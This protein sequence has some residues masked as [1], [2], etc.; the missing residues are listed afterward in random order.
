T[1]DYEELKIF[2]YDPWA[3]DG[4]VEDL[5]SRFHVDV[6]AA[7]QR[8]AADVGSSCDWM[9]SACTE[10]SNHPFTIRRQLG[11]EVIILRKFLANP[12]PASDPKDADIF[13]V[14]AL[15]GS[16]CMGGLYDT[17][18]TTPLEEFGDDLFE[19]LPFYNAETRHRHLF[20]GS[21]D[22]R[23]LPLDI[24]AQSLLLS[25]GASWGDRPGHL[26]VPPSVT[27][28]ELQVASGPSTGEREILFFMTMVPNNPIRHEIYRQLEGLR[29]S[30]VVLQELDRSLDVW[31]KIKERRFDVVTMDHHAE[32][33]TSTCVV[34]GAADHIDCFSRLVVSGEESRMRSSIFC[35]CPPAENTAA[36]TKR[37]FDAI[38]SGCIPVVISFPTLW[39]S[40]ISWWRTD[41]APIEW[42]LPFPSD[43]Q[44]RRLVVEVSEA[45]LLKGSYGLLFAAFRSDVEEK[46]RYIAEVRDLLV[47][48]L[49]GGRQ[50]AF[51]VV[52]DSLRRILPRLYRAVVPLSRP[53]VC[54]R[55]PLLQDLSEAGAKGWSS[56]YG[57]FA[58]DP[59]AFWHRCSDF[60]SSERKHVEP[61]KLSGFLRSFQLRTPEGSDAPFLGPRHGRGRQALFY[62]FSQDFVKNGFEHRSLFTG[63]RPFLVCS[64]PRFP[65]ALH[66]LDATEQRRQ[67]SYVDASECRIPPPLPPVLRHGPVR[68][69]WQ[70]VFAVC[71]T[72]AWEN[73][74]DVARIVEDH[75]VLPMSHDFQLVAYDACQ[76][77]VENVG[78]TLVE[79]VLALKMQQE[80]GLE[81]PEVVVFFAGMVPQEVDLHF[82]IIDRLQEYFDALGGD[83]WLVSFDG[84]RAPGLLC[85]GFLTTFRSKCPAQELQPLSRSSPHVLAFNTTILNRVPEVH[86]QVI[87]AE[88]HSFHVQIDFL[89]VLSFKA[90]RSLWRAGRAKVIADSSLTSRRD[91]SECSRSYQQAYDNYLDRSGFHLSYG[92]QALRAQA[93]GCLDWNGSYSLVDTGLP[94][95]FDED[96]SWAKPSGIDAVKMDFLK[97][98]WGANVHNHPPVPEFGSSASVEEIGVFSLCHPPLCK[99][100]VTWTLELDTGCKLQIG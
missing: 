8:S 44:W 90:I 11:Q 94:A 2:I 59:M 99:A 39:G 42:S 6:H 23:N 36:G 81:I 17:H 15:I 43:V 56:S 54:E 33:L 62:N 53:L 10:S 82:Q 67:V 4:T 18:C 75:W 28:V 61:L 9:L 46:Q 51:S 96:S 3:I 32:S 89:T 84:H 20:L 71:N 41:G 14:P 7:V 25:C 5:P 55:I 66:M 73:T 1:E 40:G 34:M 77:A 76:D 27:D 30:K 50:D 70:L 93:L 98:A 80:Q 64:N 95:A 31:E 26:V 29:G 100:H 65:S 83:P 74:Q 38:L 49:A 57:E 47:Y 85:D 86:L 72:M 12:L 37:L 24:Q 22:K 21:I 97:T 19:L 88:S 91:E 69:L 35:L 45:E 68:A 16:A 92:N 52:M 63:E 58:C 78:S 79:H 60:W 48:D 13:V 87:A